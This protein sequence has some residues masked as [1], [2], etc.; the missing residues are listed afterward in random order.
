MSA[1]SD[2]TPSTSPYN[3]RS[4]AR[5]QLQNLPAAATAS[6]DYY[7]QRRETPN[8]IRT[9]SAKKIIYDDGEYKKR[10]K[11]RNNENEKEFGSRMKNQFQLSRSPSKIRE[12]S[13]K[14]EKDDD[15]DEEEEEEEEEDEEEE[16]E[17]EEMHESKGY[18]KK[19]ERKHKKNRENPK[20]TIVNRPT[21]SRS[22]ISYVVFLLILLIPITLLV[23]REKDIYIYIY[24]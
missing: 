19:K 16:E 1:P 23:R 13:K 7:P 15:D 10:A 24:T 5:Q 17:E 20:V 8:R 12:N 22:L 3:T 6:A 9:F 2:K 14:I 18:N 21:A 11:S 4:K